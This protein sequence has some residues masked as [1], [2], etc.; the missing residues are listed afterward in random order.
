M[1]LR[2]LIV[3]A[4]SLGD[5]VYASAVLADIRRA[6]PDAA[7]D[8]VVEE[9]FTDIPRLAGAEA[10]IPFALRRWRKI[11]WRADA[12]RELAAFRKKLRERH[13]DLVIDLNEQ[14]K[15][16]LIAYSADAEIRHGF[17]WK[18]IREPLA[19]LGYQKTYAVPR[20]LHF[21]ERCRLL[22]S[23]ALQYETVGLPQW[24]WQEENTSEL[25]DKPYVVLLSASSRADKL[26][27]DMDWR[28]LIAACAERNLQ[29]LL[30]WG[31]ANE[32]A[33]CRRLAECFANAQVLPKSSLAS[34]SG[35]LRNAHWAV[36]IDT[37]LTH[38]SAALG[39]PTVAVFTAT[40]PKRLG[41][42]A[43]GTHAKDI[44]ERGAMPTVDEVL[45]AVESLSSRRDGA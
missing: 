29:V 39:T 16:A 12:W 31:S 45:T 21:V 36:G 3:R 40:S 4:S 44:G 35:I 42:A 32:E 18:S 14:V 9:A 30:P 23:R 43:Q 27:R 22:A 10:V 15:S 17:D 41:V 6:Y 19:V 2:I 28:M 24:R 20:D 1:S 7:V 38:W 13:Y 33:R 37:G 5:V 8:W 34:L 26:W 25:P 11:W